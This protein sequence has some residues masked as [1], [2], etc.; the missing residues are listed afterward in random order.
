MDTTPEEIG[1]SLVRYSFLNTTLHKLLQKI[2]PGMANDK[3]WFS[4]APKIVRKFWKQ[5]QS[6]EFLFKLEMS[7]EMNGE[8]KMIL[9]ISSFYSIIR[10]MYEAYAVFYHL[11]KLEQN[12]EENIIRFRLWEIDGLRSRLKFSRTELSQELQERLE[13]DKKYIDDVELIVQESSF[14][15]NLPESQ[16]TFLLKSCAWKFSSISLKREKKYWQHSIKELI[17]RTS[18]PSTI[19]IDMYSYYSMHVHTG[20]ISILQN[21]D[22]PEEGKLT[23]KWVAITNACFVTAH[24]LNDLSKMFAEGKPFLESL[25]Q[26]EKECFQSFIKK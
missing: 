4:I 14:F 6:L 15:R 16:K 25:T 13:G 21:D 9:D 18:L 7:Y 22:L 12:V 11:F 24:I 8:E 19:L 3:R 23:A 5:A 1:E 2:E 26:K 10:A 17:E 20:Y